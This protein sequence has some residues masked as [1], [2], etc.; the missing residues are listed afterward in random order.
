VLDGIFLNETA[1]VFHHRLISDCVR[2]FSAIK[3]HPQL[4]EMNQVKGKGLT[5]GQMLVDLS[6][7]LRLFLNRPDAELKLAAT[8][9]NQRLPFLQ[10]IHIARINS[11]TYSTYLAQTLD[12]HNPY[13]TEHFKNVLSPFRGYF[14]LLAAIN[15]YN[16]ALDMHQEN[17]QDKA[18][19]LVV[20]ALKWLEDLELNHLTAMSEEILFALREKLVTKVSA[21]QVAISIAQG[22]QVISAKDLQLMVDRKNHRA[23]RFGLP[24]FGEVICAPTVA[25]C[26]LPDPQALQLLYDNIQ[27][28]VSSNKTQRKQILF[29][30]NLATGHVELLD[31]AF[32]ATIQ[33][34]CLINVSSSHLVSQ[35]YFLQ[36]LEHQLQE[37]NLR[38]GI[39]ACQTDIQRDGVSCLLYAYAL[40]GIVARSS[41]AKLLDEK[42]ATSPPTFFDVSHQEGHIL[43]E[44]PNVR[45]C[46]L[47]ALGHKTSLMSQ[48]FTLM[49]TSLRQFYT[50]EKVKSLIADFKTKYGLVNSE[51]LTSKRTYIDYLRNHFA[52]CLHPEALAHQITMQGLKTKYKGKA[53][54]ID[55]GQMARRAVVYGTTDEF[56]VVLEH[57]SQL[58][59]EDNPL[60]AP[61]KN[62][63]LTPI[64]HALQRQTPGRALKLLATEKISIEKAR[65][66]FENLPDASPLKQNEALRKTLTTVA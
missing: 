32:D 39:I 62:K 53:P 13:A 3:A 27:A 5:V 48:S 63:G 61:D 33:K 43:G 34:L 8:L 6:N 14:L 41:F 22:S 16:L 56:D 20:A 42:F 58:T 44:I 21:L 59:L 52:R 25:N 45:W 66:H 60:D 9:S 40:S 29:Y 2:Q 28:M 18:I 38:F 11:M 12:L 50:T 19:Q 55:N 1:M 7:N 35:H 49:E 36:Q 10:A 23:A 26:Y 4:F 31:V 47:H 64:W 37:R 57:F 30:Y 65:E 54:D 17:K 46:T 24:Y 51:E 15:A